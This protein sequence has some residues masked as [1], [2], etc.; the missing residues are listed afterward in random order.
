[1]ICGFRKLQ[2]ANCKLQIHSMCIY[3]QRFKNTYLHHFTGVENYTN[4]ATFC[5]YFF[6]LMKKTPRFVCVFMYNS[7]HY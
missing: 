5:L 4:D 2:I 1:M 6:C 3:F 7:I